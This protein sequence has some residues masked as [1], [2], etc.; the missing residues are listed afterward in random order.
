MLSLTILNFSY[1]TSPKL[2]FKHIII[3]LCGI[4]NHLVADYFDFRNKRRS[5]AL[6][7]LNKF[8]FYFI[9]MQTNSSKVCVYGSKCFTIVADT[10]SHVSEGESGAVSIE[11]DSKE[12]FFYT[13]KELH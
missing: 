8:Q 6:L 7:L 5:L 11:R 9:N 3:N 4:L 12:W 10:L 1:K 2:A 13:L